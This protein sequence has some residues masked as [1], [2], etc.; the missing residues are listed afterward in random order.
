MD[1]DIERKFA[2]QEIN[3]RENFLAMN[4]LTMILMGPPPNRTNG[5]R[6]TLTKLLDDFE[7]AMDWAHDI[8]NV[9]RREECLGLEEIGKV[10]NEIKIVRDDLNILK[11]EVG[12][13]AVAKTN[14]KGVYVVG[15]LQ[16]IAAIAVAFIMRG[17]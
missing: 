2:Q 1:E 14:L 15:L 6:G 7:K 4:D 8:W 16:F 3:I 11:Q 10:R 17:L 13:M 9:K 12:D 5:M